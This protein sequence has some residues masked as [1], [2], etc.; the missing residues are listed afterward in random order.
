VKLRSSKF[1]LAVVTGVTLATTVAGAT[2][3]TAAPGLLPAQWVGAWSM[4]PAV[5]GPLNASFAGF[6]D[7][8]LRMIVRSS[9]SGEG[10]RAL[11]SNALGDRHI[12]LTHATIAQPDTSTPD[13]RADVVASSVKQLTFAGSPSVTVPR[14]GQVFSDPVTM[15]VP[16]LSELVV[17]L[18]FQAP[19]GLPTFHNVANSQAFVGTGDLT[20][21]TTGAGFT[22]TNRNNFFFLTDIEVQSRR[23]LGSVVV[24]G[25]SIADG[26]GSTFNGNKRW[27]D[28]LANRLI[29]QR[30]F[31]PFEVGV[32]NGHRRQRDHRA[33]RCRGRRRRLRRQRARPARP[34]RIRAD[35]GAAG[36][37][38]PRH[39]RHRP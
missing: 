26:N 5:P 21:D 12:S 33:R 31:G 22:I 29:A 7:Q 17:T 6:T 36:V 10:V 19:T 18:Y 38:V 13:V 27:P 14:G 30:P 9:I 4:S 1:V 8:S 32:L 15:N 28:Q 20:S 39:Q 25:D 35:R 11:V 23:S 3:S 16:A 34:G 37:R 24:I 2:V